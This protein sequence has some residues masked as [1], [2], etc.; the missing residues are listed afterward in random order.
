MSR[1]G[2][3]ILVRQVASLVDGFIEAETFKGGLIV[4]DESIENPDDWEILVV[5][6]LNI[7]SEECFDL[8]LRMGEALVKLISHDPSNANWLRVSYRLELAH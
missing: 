2:M 8:S 1:M 5:T 6:K 7:S 3:T 4:Y